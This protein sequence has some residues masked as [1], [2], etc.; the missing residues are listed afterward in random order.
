MG[1]CSFNTAWLKDERYSKWLSVD[2]A[3]KHAAFCLVCECVFL[4]TTMGIKAFDSHIKSEKHGKSIA[5]CDKELCEESEFDSEL[6]VSGRRQCY[7]GGSIVVK[8]IRS[9]FASSE[10]LN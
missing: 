7:T 5:T 9:T 10:T 2:R 6:R 8:D 1:K 4:L 3:N